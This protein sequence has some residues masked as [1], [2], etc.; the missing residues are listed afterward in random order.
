MLHKLYFKGNKLVNYSNNNDL[1]DMLY[2]FIYVT[3][4]FLN[5]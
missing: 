2:L 3:L 1:N 5:L 4:L